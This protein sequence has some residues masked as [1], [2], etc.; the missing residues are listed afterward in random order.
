[1]LEKGEESKWRGERVEGFRGSHIV[2]AGGVMVRCLDLYSNY[3]GESVG[4]LRVIY[5][6]GSS[7]QSRC[8]KIDT[9]TQSLQALCEI[10]YGG[11]CCKE[12]PR[13]IKKKN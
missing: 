5:R 8:L 13:K 7:A 9:S 10:L 11:W 4:M 6:K 12:V 3:G 2:W 1:M